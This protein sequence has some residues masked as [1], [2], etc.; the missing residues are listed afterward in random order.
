MKS[1]FLVV[2]LVFCLQGI[3]QAQSKY[4][5][6]EKYI[7]IN[8]THEQYEGAVNQLF[9][10]LENQYQGKNINEST[11]EEV[12]G[13]KKEALKDIKRR[14]ISAYESYFSESD[15]N[16]MYEFYQTDAG[17]QLAKDRNQLSKQQL[18]EVTKFYETAVGKKIQ[19]NAEPLGQTISDISTE[20]SH[21]L[22]A[23][24]K[25]ILE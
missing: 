23:E 10:L 13:I 15:I 18:K 6:T 24:A 16:A 12:R 9:D 17:K 20:W 1:K 5:N 21:L 25:N 11:W 14:L 3:L 19:E 8:G 22:Y 4:E 2:F 7:E